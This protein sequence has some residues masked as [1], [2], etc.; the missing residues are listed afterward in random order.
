MTNLH[1]MEVSSH[2]AVT[3]QETKSRFFPTTIIHGA[4]GLYR[5]QSHFIVISSQMHNFMYVVCVS[6]IRLWY[7]LEQGHSFPL[8]YIALSICS[9]QNIHADRLD[10]VGKHVD[11][12]IYI[13]IFIIPCS[14]LS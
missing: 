8:S 9:K 12:K 7:H 3:L 4:T 13:Y 2:T 5:F 6:S 1:M 14:W 11:R 10:T